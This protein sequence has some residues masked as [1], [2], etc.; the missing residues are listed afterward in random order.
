[1]TQSRDV[2]PEAERSRPVSMRPTIE[3]NFPSF[4]EAAPD[5]MVIVGR[6][7]CIQL[8]NGQAER[9][10]GYSRTELIG[11]PIEV[12]V[13]Q[14]YR[15]KHPDDR[16]RYF[17]AP[18]AR[19]MGAGIELY[20][21][22]KDGTEFP[23]EISLGPVETSDGMLVT[24]AIR[25][26]TSRKRTEDKFRGFLE[27]APDAV[28]I[29]SRDGNIVLVNSQTER[30]FGYSRSEL[31]GRKVDVLV[32][33]RFRSGHPAHRESFFTHPKVRAMGSGL[34]LY[35]LRK[36]RSEFPVEIS[37][38]PLETE[39]GLLVASAIRDITDR[40]R[41][42]DKFRGFLE[43][44]P[45]AIV[46][47]NRQGIIVL[48]NAQTERLFG[49]PR[50]AL[51]GKPVETL[52]PERF[53]AHHPKHR[54]DFFAEPKTRAMG[55]GLELYGLRSD[56][57]EFPIEIS[58]S[59]LETEE[60]M[61]ISSAIRDITDRKRAEDKFRG[62][63]E[64]A[65]DAIVI[66]NRYGNVV[67]VNAQT[68]KLFGYAR[69]ELLGQLIEKLVPERFRAKHPKHR[70]EF[71]SAPK[72]RAMGSGLELFGLRRDGTE[73]PIEISLSPLET[74][75]GTLVSAAIR[76]ITE[77]K[78]AEEKFRGL[79]ESAPDA[80]VIV[81]SAG[82]VMLI[83]AQTEKLFGY[84]REEI[85]GQWVELL[86]P[87]RFRKQHP[88]HRSS[89]F[90]D[91]Q[92]RAMGSGLELYGRRKD[93]SEFPIEI[94][95]SPLKTEEGTLVSSA[96][97]DISERKKAEAKFRGLLESA[98]DAMVI[99]NRSGQIVL[100][101]SQTEKLF[102]YTREELIGQLV[103][104]LVPE[105]FRDRH[106][107]HR[108]RY[109]DDPKV[110]YMGSG[111]ELHGRRKDGTE[112]PVEISLSPLETEE[113]V[114]VSS[115]IRDIT[116]RKKV[117]EL[118]SRL[119]AIVDSSDDAVIGMRLNGSIT[120]WN[121]GAERVFGYTAEESTDRSISM[122]L[123]PGRVGEEATI[124]EQLQN[125]E[126]VG[127]FESL[128]RRKDGHDIHVSVTI[129]P[130]RDSRGMIIGAS[131]VARD[132]TERRRAEDALARAKEAAE[133]ANRELESFS[134][135]VAHDLRAP[136]RG[137]DGFS[138]VLLEDYADKLDAEGKRVLNKVRDSAQHM[139]QLIESLLTLARVTQTDIRR[140]P[141]DVSE[142]ARAAADRLRREDKNRALELVITPGLKD[143]GDARLLGVA[144]DNM[145]GN[146]W[147]F[148][149]KRPDARVEFGCTQVDGQTAYFLRDNGA[150]FDMAHSAK[151][152]G[153][154]Q[155]LHAGNEFEGT[156]IGLA[157]V[158]RIIRRHG[159]R[160]WAESKPGE[161]A[162]FYFT[163]SGKGR[164]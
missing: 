30:L 100:I 108:T 38:S 26:V 49:H 105:R 136:L 11:C 15:A 83:N 102:D 135:S 90:A 84:A 65:P 93:G 52:V 47:V 75:E 45:D 57:S 129:S 19:A 34:G 122:L 142:V 87:E 139:A 35:G 6:D 62:F 106:P 133:I 123:P 161:G 28:V 58:L 88:S 92:A 43:S 33:E 146:A 118:R 3:S 5:A 113:G 85:V 116:E 31:I 79:L 71:F 41:A 153:V 164:E 8:V 18:R 101:N 96:I 156:G 20:A 141:I 80:M 77:R 16:L 157:T 94:S 99:V 36:D 14:R 69:Q 143:I 126:R 32:P 1:M 109:F 137:I 132:I 110:R 115:T 60:G 97:R 103:D 131:N 151:L 120:S 70:A 140:E 13:P 91:P 117:E 29:V 73:F 138:Q 119:A 24:A 89:F 53:R 125:G 158:Q 25:D 76:D 10:F 95:L 98:P 154:F 78:K 82:R 128:R 54:S 144:F 22:R 112:F 27:A 39:D 159:G 150:G 2:D 48:V 68:E 162:T 160:I 107:A 155:R 86:V 44:A 66:V 130:I 42:E 163:L 50:S 40:K 72:V 37:L 55:S 17:A 12:L 61:L 23:A 21:V 147:K 59:P 152:F 149:R 51:V 111:L 127:T 4:L 9:L 74:E 67:L 148:T 134:Y 104:Q 121:R 56:G 46:I 145:L 81:N 7:G 114:L 63:L 124:L 64:A